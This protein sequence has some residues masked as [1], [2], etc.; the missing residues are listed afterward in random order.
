[1][2]GDFVVTRVRDSGIGIKPE[3]LELLF[4]PFQ[5]LDSGLARV[6]EGTGLGL[7]ICKRIIEMLGGEISVKS[8]LGQ[9]STFSFSLPARIGGRK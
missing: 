8:E 5:Q 1:M 4:R 2:Q 6:Y 9:G 3:D 7:S